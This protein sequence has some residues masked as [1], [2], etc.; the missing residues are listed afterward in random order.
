MI[1]KTSSFVEIEI[2]END[3]NIFSMNRKP[4]EL[5]KKLKEK[6]VSS[7]GRKEAYQMDKGTIPCYAPSSSPMGNLK[8][9]M[10]DVDYVNVLHIY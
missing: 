5:S 10:S 6:I 2:T 3:L 7:K 8:K 9:E 1:A 4:L